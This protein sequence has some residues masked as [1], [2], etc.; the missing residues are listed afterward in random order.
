MRRK[1]FKKLPRNDSAFAN[2]PSRPGHSSLEWMKRDFRVTGVSEPA[3][4][5]AGLVSQARNAITPAP[6]LA[7]QP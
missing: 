3:A 1:D 4:Y 6:Q 2:M 5:E 7:V